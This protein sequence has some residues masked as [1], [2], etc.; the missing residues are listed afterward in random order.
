M[1]RKETIKKI[2]NSA[3]I[4]EAQRKIALEVLDL[5]SLKSW[6]LKSLGIEEEA[7]DSLKDE[8][9]NI[10]QASNKPL[11]A[12]E[13]HRLLEKD[14]ISTHKVVGLLCSLAKKRKVIIANKSW[15]RKQSVLLG[16]AYDYPH[17]NVSLYM[18]KVN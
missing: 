2:I 14:N 4:T 3:D 15:A 7:K 17:K 9:L 12:L 13:V 8:I 10:L 11:T 18:A 1:A 6:E 16:K 5:L